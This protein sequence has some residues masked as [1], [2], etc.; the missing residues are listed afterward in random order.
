MKAIVSI[1]AAT[2]LMAGLS[3]DARADGPV[4]VD[5]PLAFY[6]FPIGPDWC[7]GYGFGIIADAFFDVTELWFYDKNGN[8]DRLRVDY[9]VHGS[10]KNSA[11]PT[12]LV[13][14]RGPW[15]ENLWIDLKSGAMASV[16]RGVNII[17]PGYGPI[18][19][20]AGR[21]LIDGNGNITFMAGQRDIA[22]GN[23]DALCQYLAG[24]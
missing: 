12:R 10:Y 19:L 24:P 1:L 20:N 14:W 4:R 9:M 2:I 11:D 8:P 5:Y 22:N 6:D 15:N 13:T 7:P 23:F 21:A 18:L 16:G 17:I 3:T